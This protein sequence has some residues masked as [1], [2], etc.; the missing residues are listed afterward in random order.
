M[1]VDYPWFAHYE[2]GVARTVEIPD[3]PVQQLLVN[4]AT[5]FPGHTA[6][7]VRRRYLPRGTRI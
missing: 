3:I 5:E 7:R 6:V 2:K 4:A 1:T